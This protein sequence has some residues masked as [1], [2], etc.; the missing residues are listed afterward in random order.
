MVA[1]LSRKN[2][3]M[4]SLVSIRI[5]ETSGLIDFLWDHSSLVEKICDTS[6]R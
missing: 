1:T 2:Y 6:L 4:I 3:R 5:E